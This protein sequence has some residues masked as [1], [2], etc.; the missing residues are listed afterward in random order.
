MPLHY[1]IDGYNLLK[2]RAF[3]S[4]VKPR[5]NPRRE[6]IDFI[7]RK[8]SPKNKVTVV[9][10]GYPD[11]LREQLDEPGV[12]VIFSRDI[13]ADDKIRK[14]LEAEPAKNLKETIVISNDRQI[15]SCAGMTGAGSSQVEEFVAPAARRIRKHN[16]P[17]TELSYTETAKINNELKKLWLK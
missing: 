6:L 5:Q 3:L 9:F 10:D 12:T 17:K 1:I 14:I 4:E 8:V 16:E 7:R 13:S 2:N 11:S 15:L